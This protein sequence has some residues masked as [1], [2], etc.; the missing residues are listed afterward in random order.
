[1]HFT[2]AA[3]A[4]IIFG[5]SLPKWQEQP[6]PVW[7]SKNAEQ[8]LRW[9]IEHKLDHIIYGLEL[10]NEVDG[11]Y[12]GADQAVNLQVLHVLRTFITT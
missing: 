2:D 4:Q 3:G 9:T 12:S 5:L 1:M 11:L 8:I 7:Q 10:G 6:E